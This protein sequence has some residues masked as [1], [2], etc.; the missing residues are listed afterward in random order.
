MTR[1]TITFNSWRRFSASTN[2]SW[3]RF[4]I[5][6]YCIVLLGSKILFRCLK[7]NIWMKNREDKNKNTVSKIKKF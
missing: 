5:L 6:L 1:L 4:G 7:F 3:A 2:S